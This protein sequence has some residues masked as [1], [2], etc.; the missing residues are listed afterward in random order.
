MTDSPPRQFLAGLADM[1]PLGLAV[2][3]FG[4]LYGATAIRHGLSAGETVLMSAIV[5][6]GSAQFLAVGLWSEPAPWLALGFAALLVNL[7]HVLM[8]ASL[9]RKMQAFPGWSRF[10]AVY[11]L[12][13]ESWALC[14]R[15]A[16]GQALTPAYYIGVAGS[17]YAIWLAT[18]A[19]GAALGGLIAH[20]ETYGLDFAFPAAF[21]SI[22]MGFAKTWRAAPVV[23]AS[24]LTALAAQHAF[25]G[26]WYV[27][28][29]AGAG[30]FAAA[31][32][33]DAA[34]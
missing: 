22:V 21:I 30:M 24:G 32:T 25:G 23:V 1:A 28:A 15:R 19:L 8:S 26:A 34:P 17:M 7:R 29:G 31:L 11:I 16:Q 33:P 3:V 9:G 6:A 20:P 4:M 18:S 2:A 27:L 14:E 10:F 13:D 12:A 5:F